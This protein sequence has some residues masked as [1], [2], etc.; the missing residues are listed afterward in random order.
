MS[1]KRKTMKK[2]LTLTALLINMKKPIPIPVTKSFN[3]PELVLGIG[4][5]V[6]SGGI[7]VTL[8]YLIF[9]FKW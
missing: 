5:V 9:P 4:E 8:L 1:R 2:I 6:L 3:V 7:I